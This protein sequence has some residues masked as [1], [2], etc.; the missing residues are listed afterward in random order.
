[1]NEDRV[2]EISKQIVQL[3]APLSPY[4]QDA[5]MRCALT[6]AENGRATKYLLACG[7]DPLSE[8]PPK[9]LSAPPASG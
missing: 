5:A 9:P 7:L 6:L 3:I 8:G 1:M 2:F 4:E